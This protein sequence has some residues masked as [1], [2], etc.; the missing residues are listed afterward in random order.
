MNRRVRHALEASARF[1][2]PSCR[3]ILITASATP[4]WAL[5]HV[6]E[7]RILSSSPLAV[8]PTHLV[9]YLAKYTPR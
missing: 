7:A 2:M 6:D 9:N 4:E 1:Q 8:H 5:C 3:T